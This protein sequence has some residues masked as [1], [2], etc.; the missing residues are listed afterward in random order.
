LIDFDL[1]GGSFRTA[2]KITNIIT[3]GGIATKTTGVLL[4]T[5]LLYELSNANSEINKIHAENYKKDAEIHRLKSL[6]K[7]L[8]A[9]QK[10][11]LKLLN[12]PLR[13]GFISRFFD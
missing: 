3:F 8:P 9:E 6:V 5:F 4:G 13:Y 11:K 10:K 7:E 1:I 12:S 2:I